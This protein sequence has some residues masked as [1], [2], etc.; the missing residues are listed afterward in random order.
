MPVSSKVHTHYLSI[1]ASS[2]QHS[3]SNEGLVRP[4]GFVEDQTCPG[5][6]IAP[7]ASF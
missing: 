6:P 3:N 1:I 4:K 2:Q 7:L 5:Q